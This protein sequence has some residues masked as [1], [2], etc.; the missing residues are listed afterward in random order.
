MIR[1]MIGAVAILAAVTPA[2]ARQRAA[3]APLL[4]EVFV[5]GEGAYHTYRI[6]SAIL[7]PKGTLLA[8]AEGRR[9]GAGDAGD[10]DLVLRRSHDGGRTWTPIQ[11]IGDNGP[12]TFGNPCAVA[13][14]RTG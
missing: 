2:P 12:N 9:A 1:S 4:I 7:T 10:I 6:P 8:F 14:R 11:V 3:A 5:A 13:D